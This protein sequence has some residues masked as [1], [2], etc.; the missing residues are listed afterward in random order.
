[1]DFA[2]DRSFNFNHV[3]TTFDAAVGTAVG[4]GTGG[5]EVSC[6]IGIANKANPAMTPAVALSGDVRIFRMF[7]G[8]RELG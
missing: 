6:R 4:T 5:A 8:R 2:G 7:I 3:R 1:M